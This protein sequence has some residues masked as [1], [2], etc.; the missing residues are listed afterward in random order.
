LPRHSCFYSLDRMDGGEN[1]PERVVMSRHIR[2]RI[3]RVL[4]VRAQ[5]KRCKLAQ[6]MR[7]LRARYENLYNAHKVAEWDVACLEQA[8][9]DIDDE[10]DFR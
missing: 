5:A 6:E 7:L 2:L 8:I 3:L 10:Q 9:K 1:P 4:R